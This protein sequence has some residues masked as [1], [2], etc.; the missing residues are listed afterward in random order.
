M[1]RIRKSKYK[2]VLHKGC[3]R[4][5]EIKCLKAPGLTCAEAKDVRFAV[6]RGMALHGLC[7]K[8]FLGSTWREKGTWVR[9]RV[10]AR[11]IAAGSCAGKPKMRIKP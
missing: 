4:V 9:C 6:W 7:A 11:T 10:Q 1:R 3:I 8:S 5:V 2:R